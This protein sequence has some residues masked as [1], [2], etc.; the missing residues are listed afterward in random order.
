MKGELFADVGLQLDGV[1]R[2]LKR[3]KLLTCYIFPSMN[4]LPREQ[5]GTQEEQTGII[6]NS[7][8]SITHV[9]SY[10]GEPANASSSS[11]SNVLH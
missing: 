9:S 2:Y 11:S 10:I 3:L 7:N 1:K 8:V 5:C 6:T 4:G